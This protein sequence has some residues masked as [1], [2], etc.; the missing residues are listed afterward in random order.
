MELTSERCGC[1][2]L[3]LGTTANIAEGIEGGLGEGGCLEAVG[4]R[5]EPDH[6][7]YLSGSV[8]CARP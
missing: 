6:R 8:I 3:V 5:K 1:C 7:S 4:L 2:D